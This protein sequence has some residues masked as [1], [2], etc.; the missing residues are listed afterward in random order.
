MKREL[1]KDEK[2]EIRDYIRITS[3][4]NPADVAA[5]FEE[6]FGTP[7]TRFAIMQILVEMTLDDEENTNGI[8]NTEKRG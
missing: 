2:K 7:V 8:H 6:K 3:P 4:L 1:T 5:H